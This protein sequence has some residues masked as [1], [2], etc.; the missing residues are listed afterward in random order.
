VQGPTIT[1]LAQILEL[2]VEYG[3]LPANPASGRRRR[4]KAAA[5]RRQW[6]EPEQVRPLVD[7]G[8]L[9]GQRGGNLTQDP[10][11]RALLPTLI[12]GGLRIGEALAL[13]WRDIDLANGRLLVR[14]SKTYAGLRTV[15]LSAELRDELIGYKLASIDTDPDRL[16]FGTGSGR[17]DT[18]Q[19]V[20]KRSTARSTGRISSW[21]ARTRQRSP[22]T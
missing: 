21:P 1:R 2:A 14:E 16:V 9:R 11:T 3:Y 12:C 22:R 17:Q 5:P 19:N 10:R 18:R 6:L 8:S 15:D 13:P 20:R 7:A 4:A